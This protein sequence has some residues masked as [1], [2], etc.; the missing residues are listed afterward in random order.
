MTATTDV[1]GMLRA[2]LRDPADDTARL[3]LADAL[4]EAGERERAEFIRV[5]CAIE[6]LESEQGTPEYWAALRDI[7]A[8]HE[9]CS[10][11][12]RLNRR[13]RELRTAHEAEWRRAGVCSTCSGAGQ[14]Y[15]GKA[16]EKRVACPHCWGGDVGGLLRTVSAGW[17]DFERGFPGRVHCR[18]EDVVNAG[19][20]PTPWALAVVKYHPVTRFVA[21]DRVPEV[22][23]SVRLPG[24]PQ[25]SF[26]WLDASRRE[27]PDDAALPRPLFAAVAAMTE[28]TRSSETTFCEFRSADAAN[29]ALATALGTWVRDAAGSSPAA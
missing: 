14:V 25:S 26:D 9:G 5:Q 27:V 2:V 22:D 23:T 24:R 20:V 29:E 11:W 7:H 1:A 4:D 6:R 3:V 28:Y 18:L 21:G 19:G 8:A 13:Q 16:G 17:V 12:C 10:A 15:A